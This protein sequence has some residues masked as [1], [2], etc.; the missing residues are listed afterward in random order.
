MLD[1]EKKRTVAE[2]AAAFHTFP[3]SNAQR[4]VYGILIIWIV[5]I[6]PLDCPSRAKL[7]FRRAGELIGTGLEETETELAIT[8]QLEIMHA[9]D[10]GR[11]QHTG[12]GAFAALHTFGRIQLP[13][14]ISGTEIL[15]FEGFWQLAGADFPACCACVA[16]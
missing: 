5:H 10:C 6:C 8:A 4:L 14:Q 9:F 2:R 11:I 7:V 12:S 13:D 3:A 15:Y 1:L 16:A